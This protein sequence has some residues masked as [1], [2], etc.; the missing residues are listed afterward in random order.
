[1]LV[2][3]GRDYSYSCSLDFTPYKLTTVNK[4]YRSV[5]TPCNFFLILNGS[6]GG[7]VLNRDQFMD[8][9]QAKF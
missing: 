3:Y 5:C 9:E 2:R 1:M 4:Q 7:D 6:T 8:L